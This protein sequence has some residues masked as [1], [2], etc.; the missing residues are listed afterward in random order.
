MTIPSPLADAATNSASIS[1]SA[2][3]VASCLASVSGAKDEATIGPHV[4]V[5]SALSVRCDHVVP[6]AVSF[7]D[8]F[9]DQAA[10]ATHKMMGHAQPLTEFAPTS[11]DP[12]KASG[13]RTLLTIRPTGARD[14]FSGP[15]HINP[16]PDAR[17]LA[18]SS[19]PDAIRVTVTY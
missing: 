5:T 17:N 18:S 2:T 12:D 9:P 8:E 10:G 11:N 13:N 14:L 1:V 15:S 6:Y 4:S 3:V 19:Y 7:S 16:T